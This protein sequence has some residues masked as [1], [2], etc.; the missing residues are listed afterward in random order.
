MSTR[1]NAVEIAEVGREVER[2]SMTDDRTVQLDP[3]GGHFLAARPHAG[4]PRL[5]RLRVDAELMQVVD[6]RLLELLQVL[7]NRKPELNQVEDRVA[8]QLTRPVLRRLASAVR[9][10]DLDFSSR[11]L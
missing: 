1:D 2:E 5:T 10:D 3:D 9:P 6:Q 11:P 4:E 7:G 8:N